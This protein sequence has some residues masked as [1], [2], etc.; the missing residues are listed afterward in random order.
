[1][2][3]Q[4][5][6]YGPYLM[7]VIIIGLF[8]LALISREGRGAS[9]IVDDDWDGA[10]HS[11]IQDA[12]NDSVKGDSIR[13]HA[14]TY[15]ELVVVN[16][17]VSIVGNGSA[18][19]TVDGQW[20]G[21][22]FNVTADDVNVHGLHIRNSGNI[23]YVWTDRSWLSNGSGIQIDGLDGLSVSNCSFE[24][25]RNGIYMFGSSGGAISWCSFEDT[26]TSIEMNIG[27]NRVK[28]AN[29]SFFNT[30]Y[31]GFLLFNTNRCSITDCSIDDSGIHWLGEVI[32]HYNTHV[33]E[34]VTVG[35]LPLTY[36]VNQSNVVIT[37][38]V[39]VV[40]VANCT[41][42]TI[43]DTEFARA[44]NDVI[45]GFSTN[46]TIVNCSFSNMGEGIDVD[47]SPW[48]RVIDCTFVD[49]WRGI[50]FRSSDGYLVE[51]C[52]FTATRWGIWT[53]SSDHFTI[54]R[55][56]FETRDGG[57]HSQCYPTYEYYGKVENCA[58]RDMRVAFDI[59][60]AK[61]WVIANVTIANCSSTG[62]R[63][64][65][66]D[67]CIIDNCS[68]TNAHT[69]ISIF[70]KC[71]R[72]LISNCTLVGNN[73]TA[74][75]IEQVSYDNTVENTRMT[76]NA[77]GIDSYDIR[78]TTI[79]NCRIENSTSLGIDM[80]GRNWTVM[81]CTFIGNGDYAIRMDKSGNSVHHNV[82]TNNGDHDS[83]ALDRGE[84]NSWDDGS[85]GNWWSDYTGADTDGDGVGNI[86]Y[87]IDGSAESKD[88]FPFTNA[89]AQLDFW[90]ELDRF[91][92]VLERSEVLLFA[93]IETDLSWNDAVLTFSVDGVVINVT[94]IN[95]T[96]GITGVTFLWEVDTHRDYALLKVDLDGILHRSINVTVKQTKVNGRTG[97]P[98]PFPF[99]LTSFLIA[100]GYWRRR[101]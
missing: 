39:S 35:G 96:E 59:D 13:V 15:E 6:P 26:E 58:F 60:Y 49:V 95:I 22:V 14:G 77:M 83:Q 57:I 19:T 10:D 31:V 90:L 101:R 92:Q 56:T 66:S 94:T 20:R 63:L 97:L 76:S 37:K 75:N 24:D 61:Y 41:N 12:I 65:R 16:A 55:C 67:D 27:C 54:R 18:V 78:R 98:G 8:M 45:I 1:M 86:P 9:I 88:R 33:I 50:S 100:S 11:S 2:T 51:N 68:I 44:F 5:G 48:C 21:S 72:N 69:G 71:D 34:N 52:T 85:E 70:Y 99:L 32:S 38:N 80:R 23:T 25:C 28:I 84:N 46:V 3:M 30:S 91:D 79:T 29:C 82:F 87:A 17:S 73:E 43:I 62:I 7:I 93:I 36:L 89:T 40:I 42:V 64:S 74:I 81:N 4:R 53:S 47:Y